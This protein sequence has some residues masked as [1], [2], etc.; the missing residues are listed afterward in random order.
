MGQDVWLDATIRLATALAVEV[1]Y[2]WLGARNDATLDETPRGGFIG[3]SSPTGSRQWCGVYRLPDV[4]G[5]NG[6]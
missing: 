6:H 2:V 5:R 3:E 1:Q 4:Y